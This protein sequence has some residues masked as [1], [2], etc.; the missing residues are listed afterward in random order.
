MDVNVPVLTKSPWSYELEVDR[1]IALDDGEVFLCKVRNVLADTYVCDESLS[2]A[3]RINAI[4][5]IHTACTTYF[6]WNGTAA[7]AWG[8]PMKQLHAGTETLQ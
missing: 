8:E 3:Q 7:G 6:N 5:P 2:A 4:R 1:S